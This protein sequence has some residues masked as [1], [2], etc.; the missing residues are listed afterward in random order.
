MSGE[1]LILIILIWIGPGLVIGLISRMLI[2]RYL[3]NTIK[4]ILLGVNGS[5]VGGLLAIVFFGVREMRLID[6]LLFVIFGAII[7]LTLYGILVNRNVSASL[8]KIH[9]RETQQLPTNNFQ[10]LAQHEFQVKICPNC[11]QT[12]SDI[13]LIFCLDDGVPLSNV[14]SVQ[15]PRDPEETVFSPK[16]R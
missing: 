8:N 14:V 7:V 5:L 13:S 11:K 10:T 16:V 9:A 15:A 3:G 6:F 12:Y 1:F 2:P 4:S